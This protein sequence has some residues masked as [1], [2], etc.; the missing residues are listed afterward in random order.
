MPITLGNIQNFHISTFK[1]QELDFEPRFSNACFLAY[2][3]IHSLLI[4]KNITL[5]VI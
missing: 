5:I 3:I 1:L 4:S 2:I